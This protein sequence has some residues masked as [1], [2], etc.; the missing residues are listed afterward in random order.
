MRDKI[1]DVLMEKAIKD[2]SY[3]LVFDFLIVLCLLP[4]SEEMN[5]YLEHNQS[6]SFLNQFGRQG[7]DNWVSKKIYSSFRLKHFLKNVSISVSSKKN[8]LGKVS[9]FRI[10]HLNIFDSRG[11]IFLDT[12]LEKS[13]K[14]CFANKRCRRHRFRRIVLL[15]D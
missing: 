14:M 3:K 7:R 12:S 10:C 11:T 1:S 8:I 4:K 6:F 9:K 5:C 2:G 13:N 15:L